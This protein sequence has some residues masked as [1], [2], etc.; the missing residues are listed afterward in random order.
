MRKLKINEANAPLADYLP[1]LGKGPLVVTVR[2]KPVAALVP[3]EGVDWE[4]LCVGT[5]PDFLDL[6]ERS[7]REYEAE[8]GISTDE[9]RR[10][11]GLPPYEERKTGKKGRKSKPRSRKS[12]GVGNDSEV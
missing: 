11:F 10:R 3:I 1:Q 8:G 7:R 6:I 12:N 4:S 9:I 2:G 5:N